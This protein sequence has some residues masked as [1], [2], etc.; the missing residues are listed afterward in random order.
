[1]CSVSSG[2]LRGPQNTPQVTTAK[3]NQGAG[4]P[5]EPGM[6]EGSGVWEKHHKENTGDLGQLWKLLSCPSTCFTLVETPLISSQLVP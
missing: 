2:I 5:G 3:E 1:M 4:A 6:G